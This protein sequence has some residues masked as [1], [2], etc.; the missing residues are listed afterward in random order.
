[1]VNSGEKW[2][3]LEEVGKSREKWGKRGEKL[4]KVAKSGIK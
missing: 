4:G 2:L 3:K 1:M